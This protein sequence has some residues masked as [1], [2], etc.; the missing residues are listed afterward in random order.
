[1]ITF[2][3]IYAFIFSS[4]CIVDASTLLDELEREKVDTPIE[5][6]NHINLLIEEGG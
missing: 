4:F 3:K 2:T 1:M 6:V 5:M